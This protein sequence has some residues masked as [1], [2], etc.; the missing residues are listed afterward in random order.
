MRPPI[1]VR[2]CQ[3]SHLNVSSIRANHKLARAI[4]RCGFYKFRRQLKY[5][6]KL[7]ESKSIVSDLFKLTSKITHCGSRRLEN[8]TRSDRVVTCPRCGKIIDRDLNAALNASICHES[9][10]LSWWT[11]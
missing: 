10:D 11:G 9:R 6:V 1:A 2:V 3:H 4:S 5:K 7:Y 8:L